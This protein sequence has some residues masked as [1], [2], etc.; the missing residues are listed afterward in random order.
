MANIIEKNNIS[1]DSVVKNGIK[2][3]SSYNIDN[4]KNEIR[5]FFE[6]KLSISLNQLFLD[7]NHFLNK[8]QIKL[9][10]SF[11]NRR[12]QGEPYQYIVGKGT[13]YGYDFFVNHHTLI[14]RPETEL[15]INVCKKN[16]FC[17]TAL[18]IGTGCGN[19]AIT[20]I[21]EKVVQKIDAID[22]SKQ[23]IEIAKN[24]CLQYNI[25]D[26]YFSQIDFLKQDI[27]K[28]YNLIVSNP[29]YISQKEYTETD[30]HVRLYEPEQ[31]LTD[32][33]MGLT[34][35]KHFA[36]NISKNL[37]KEGCLVIEIGL[38]NTKKIINDLFESNDFYCYW[39]RDL[40]G[41]YRVAEIRKNNNA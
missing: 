34:F 40:N 27:K 11:L 36:K 26:I 32:N 39:H 3:L 38:E 13:F 16:G 20:L 5:W 35:Y 22:I 6:E 28:Q 10:N 29:P 30:D 17:E 18:D 15:I 7:K 14:P 31:A 1:I 37:K 19:I 21:K 8:S 24:N 25:N 9:F 41:N 23:A 4:A 12:I 2:K 33:S